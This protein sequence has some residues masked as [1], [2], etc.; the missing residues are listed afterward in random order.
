[1]VTSLVMNQGEQNAARALLQWYVDMGVDEAI[2]PAPSDF[3][4]WRKSDP[5]AP[6]DGQMALQKKISNKPD[7]EVTDSAD[8]AIALAVE[9]AKKCNTFEELETAVKNFDGCSLKAGAKNTVFADGA[10]DADLLVI[11]EAP[12]REEDRIGKPFVGARRSTIGSNV[13]GDRPVA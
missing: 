7:A 2:L 13:S 1:M 4:A 11:G 12:G 5:L 9:Y 6:S 8:E 3:F 10:P